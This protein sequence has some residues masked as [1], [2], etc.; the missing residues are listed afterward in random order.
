MKSV[1]VGRS[2]WLAFAIAGV[3]L[4]LA[5]EISM[6]SAGRWSTDSGSPGGMGRKA[7]RVGE[8]LARYQQGHDGKLPE[9]LSNLYPSI[10]SKEHL[11]VLL[12]EAL[13]PGTVDRMSEADVRN[14]IETN[15]EFLY[16]GEKGRKCD[17]ILL[18]RHPVELDS[19][20]STLK[21]W[22]LRADLSGGAM[23][24]GD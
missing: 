11:G 3:G 10:I 7:S 18:A 6:G 24:L 4:L 21:F 13:A 5:R 2:V 9:R 15:T 17:V 1:N 23:E 22:H 14:F 16:L 12:H 19:S 20:G 8:F